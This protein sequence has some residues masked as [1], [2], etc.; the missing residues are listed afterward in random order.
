MAVDCV[1][2][3][4]HRAIDAAGWA[5]AQVAMV[6]ADVRRDAVIVLVA[7]GLAHPVIEVA[8]LTL[9]TTLNGAIREPTHTTIVD[10]LVVGTRTIEVGNTFNGFINTDAVHTSRALRVHAVIV[11]VTVAHFF[12]NTLTKV[13]AISHTAVLIPLANRRWLGT[14]TVLAYQAYRMI[15]I[16]P[17]GATP[18]TE[19]VDAFLAKGT[20][21]VRPAFAQ[22]FTIRARIARRAVG[23]LQ[24][25][26]AQPRRHASH[27]LRAVL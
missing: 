24:T 1:A 27:S 23:V 25:L 16:V 22:A 5:I 11:R 26:H 13:A 18:Y 12:F 9:L 6:I 14:L 20:I 2:V 3:L 19:I 7:A 4:A 10:T 17:G 8:P 15:A 21:V